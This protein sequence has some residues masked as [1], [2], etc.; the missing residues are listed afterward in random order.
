[1]SA[2]LRL[3]TVDLATLPV[4]DALDVLDW[5]SVVDDLKA[6]IL[7][8]YPDASD[9]IDDDLEPIV[10]LLRTYADRELQ[11]RAQWNDKVRKVLLASSTGTTL[12]HLGAKWGV[13]RM[14]VQEE[15]PAA[16]PPRERIMESDDRFRERIQLAP[17][18]FATAGSYE[19]YRFHALTADIRIISVE[20]YN[21]ASGVGLLPGQVGVVTLT[22][23]PEDDFAA[24]QNVRVRLARPDIA[25]MTADVSVSSA[26]RIPVDVT[27]VQFVKFG[28][29]RAPVLAA[30]KLNVDNYFKS[31]KKV[32][33]K[34]ARSGLDG[35]LHGA[36]VEYVDLRK[37]LLDV[38]PG[39][40]GVVVPGVIDITAE[41]MSV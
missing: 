37:P 14:V 10:Y 27:A 16:N 34:L 28:P 20:A 29:S 35:A 19:A 17:A 5:T 3:G 40:W 9:V 21:H 36:G 18:A 6:S 25:P 30:G 33:A 41:A 15:D 39:P 31:R 22:E 7:L 12:D 23:N 8:K 4:P 24:A 11:L 26:R 1:M 13:S 38:D 32:S 2:G